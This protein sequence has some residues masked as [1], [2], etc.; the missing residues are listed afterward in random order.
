MVKLASNKFI[1]LN[2]ETGRFTCSVECASQG[3][4]WK[5]LRIF[6]LLKVENHLQHF[7]KCWFQKQ[8]IECILSNL[9]L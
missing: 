2:T 9:F 1:P 3:F 8:N 6:K 7:K 4:Y 5:L